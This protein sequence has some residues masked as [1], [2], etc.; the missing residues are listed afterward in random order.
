M[1]R[2]Y[3]YCGTALLRV[4]KLLVSPDDKLI[5]F[6]SF[7]GRKFDD[8]PRAIYESMLNDKRFADYKFVWAFI[9]PDKFDVPRGQKIGTD[10]LRYYVTALK[11]R[12][13]VTNSTIERGLSFKGKKTFYYDTWHGTPLKTMGRDVAAG[14]K[15]FGT[16]GGFPV[17]VMTAQG[18]YEADIFSRVFNI[19]RDNFRVIGLPRNDELVNFTD[20]R[21]E[22]LRAQLG[23]APGTTAILYAPTYREYEQSAVG[24]KMSLPVDFKKWRQVLGE[25]YKLLFRAHYEVAKSMAITD[26]GFVHN[27]SDYSSLNDLMIA[28]DV[29]ITDY[30]SLFFD[31]S[32][33]GKPMLCFAYDYDEYAAKRGLYFDVRELLPSAESEDALLSLLGNLP[34]E[35]VEQV[36][37]FREKYVTEFGRAAELS[38]DIIANEL[39][40]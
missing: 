26:D 5:L 14:N 8:S 32:I 30:S 16:K 12:V 20:S 28:S 13:W 18:D 37:V 19:P 31:Y 22:Q 11:A 36:K 7:G 1:Y 34:L 27:V 6:S 10:G 35:A 24:V 40:M 21:R 9:D 33:M 15:A 17:D 39:K 23:I 2:V 38:L 3:Y 4:L 25:S 29:L